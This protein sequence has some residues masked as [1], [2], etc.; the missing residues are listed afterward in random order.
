MAL[1][2]VS[3]GEDGESQFRG[4]VGMEGE[5][6]VVLQYLGGLQVAGDSCGMGWPAGLVFV[7]WTQ[8]NR[9]EDH[10][11]LPFPPCA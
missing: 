4:G 9:F 11:P 5:V 6:S 2:W 10:G 8:E 1:L 3:L 7:S